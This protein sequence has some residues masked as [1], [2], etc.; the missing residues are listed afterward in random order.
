[1]SFIDFTGRAI[2]KVDAGSL[3]TS[4][5]PAYEK[6][7]VAPNVAATDNFGNRKT[8]S[9]ATLNEASTIGQVPPYPS[10]T[11]VVKSIGVEQSGTSVN[12]VKGIS[13]TPPEAEKTL[14]VIKDV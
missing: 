12:N 1:M 14:A 10:I 8:Q 7:G 6:Q 9:V 2:P 5:I 11:T 3:D 13:L 4:F